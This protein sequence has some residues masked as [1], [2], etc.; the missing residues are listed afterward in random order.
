MTMCDH[1]GCTRQAEVKLRFGNGYWRHGKVKHR[2]TYVRYCFPCYQLVDR[3]FTL[4]DVSL[5]AQAA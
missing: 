4:C 5:L 1:A 3:L 2:Q